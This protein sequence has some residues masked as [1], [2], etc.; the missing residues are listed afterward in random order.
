VIAK[1]GADILRLWVAASDYSDDLRIGP[2]ILKTFVETY[3]K[4]RNTLR[5]MLGTLAHHDAGKAVAH[6][7]MPSLEKYMLHLLAE[8]DPQIRKAYA[9]YDYKKVV[10]LLLH[11]MNTDL[12][13]FYFDIRKDALYCEAPSSPK[14]LAALTCVEHIFRHVTIWLAP[15]LSFTA[16]E[17]WLARYPEL[18]E[19]GSVHLE[20]FPAVPGAWTNAALDQQWDA[21]RKV[22]S[23]VTGALEIER[24]AKRIGSSLEA[25]P[26]VHVTDA[27][28]AKA[29]EGIDLAEIAITSGVTLAATPAPADAFTLSDVAG[30][31]VVPN[32]AVGTKC[33][34]SWRITTDV[35]SDPDYPDLSKRD[36]AAMREIDTATKTQG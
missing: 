6:A 13:A 4:M 32:R 5:W 19:A 31:A 9:A 27:A 22:R 34:R 21:I 16:D 1:S 11:F 25:A 24:A 7:D 18:A 15:I 2:E 30:I 14:R 20:T 17:A 35:G 36:A 23:V 12:S 28:L 26:I 8:L 3:R 33:A 29:L 10:S